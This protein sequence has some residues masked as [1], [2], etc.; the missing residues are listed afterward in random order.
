MRMSGL[1]L[2]RVVGGRTDLVVEFLSAGG[3]AR[4]HDAAGVALISWCA[5]Y[6]DV[7]A[8]RMLLENGESL[9]TLGPDMG[10]NAAAFHGYW[11]LCQFLVEHGAP[12]NYQLPE[13][14]ETPLHSALCSDDRLL[15]DP[16]VKVLI[17]AGAN[18]NALTTVGVSTGSFMRDCRTRGES[19]LHRAAAFGSEATIQL[20]LDAGAD[21]ELRDKNGDSPLSWASW[22]RRPAEVLRM[23]NFAP[24]DIH[25]ENRPMRASL[26][27]DP[28]INR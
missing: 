28:K 13:T 9:Q 2:A 1:S 14:S 8:T 3:D 21:R 11:R 10:L 4:E 17:A 7:S 5:Y 16:V 12:A 26:I 22:Y 19:P 18:P 23:L 24:H 27:G 20:L 15:Y 25:P 6:G